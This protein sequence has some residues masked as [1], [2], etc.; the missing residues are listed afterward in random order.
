MPDGSS[1]KGLT[2]KHPQL[3]RERSKARPRAG[4]SFAWRPVLDAPHAATAVAGGSDLW[5]ACEERS[6]IRLTLADGQVLTGNYTS[7]AG[8]HFLHR[9][10]HGLPLI[11]EVTGPYQPGDVLAVDVVRTRAQVLADA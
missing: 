4:L 9:T 5:T 3:S 6:V 2:P 7:R 11:G 10:S 8:M 1:G